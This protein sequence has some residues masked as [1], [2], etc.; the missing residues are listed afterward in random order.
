MTDHWYLMEFVSWGSTYALRVG[1]YVK[2][3]AYSRVQGGWVD[4][5]Q[6]ARTMQSLHKVRT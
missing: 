1:G 6:S 5:A 4:K 2:P 3:K